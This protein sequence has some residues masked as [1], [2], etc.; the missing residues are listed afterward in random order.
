MDLYELRLKRLEADY[1][2]TIKA[3]ERAEERRQYDELHPETPELVDHAI[4][5]EHSLLNSDDDEKCRIEP[6]PHYP[7]PTVEPLAQGQV[8]AIKASMQSVKFRHEPSWAKS[9]KDDQLVRMMRKI[10]ESDG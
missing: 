6:V 1:A 8:D 10:I 9:L 3:G 7:R 5:I 2:E 4:D